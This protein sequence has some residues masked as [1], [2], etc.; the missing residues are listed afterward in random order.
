MSTKYTKPVQVPGAVLAKRL[1][2]ISEAVTKKGEDRDRELTMRVPAE[3]DRD[4]DLVLSEAAQRLHQHAAMAAFVN[5]A[6][7]ACFDGGGL[8]GA[9]IQERGAELGL[10]EAVAYDPERHTIDCE[11]VEPGE[12]IYVRAAWLGT[13]D[14]EES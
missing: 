12:T 7:N 6:I 9:W 11:E 2:E 3:L 4:A 13:K 8:D 14:E 10:V 1:E 5:D